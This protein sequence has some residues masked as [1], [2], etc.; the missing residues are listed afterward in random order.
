MFM[1]NG[2]VCLM[3]DDSDWSCRTRK[4]MILKPEHPAPLNIGHHGHIGG[5]LENLMRE[6]LYIIGG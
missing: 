1:C 5:L 3:E 4:L 2:F 6:L